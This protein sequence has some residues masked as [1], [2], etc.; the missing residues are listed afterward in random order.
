MKEIK[1]LDVAKIKRKDKASKIV[2]AILRT[3][4]IVGLSFIIILP[5]I[6]SAIPALTDFNY[7]GEP[8]SIWLPKKSSGLSFKIASDLMDYKSSLPKTIFFAISIS[9]IQVIVSA[10]VGYGFTTLGK[11]SGKALFALVILTIILPPQA[12]MLPQ[13]MYFTKMGLI[14]NIG[15][16]Y[17]LS[18]F[19]MGLKSGLFIY[20]FK[21]F[22]QGLPKELE[23]AA[24]IDGCGYVGTFFRVMLP[25][26]TS[27]MLTVFVFAFVW[28]FGD[29]HYTM[30]F[31]KDANLMPSLVL[32]KV[33]NTGY[34]KGSFANATFLNPDDMPLLFEGSVRGAGLILY[35]APLA[36]FYFLIQRSFVQGFER[37][38]ITGQ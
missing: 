29:L 11:G 13:F 31:A 30:W 16:I 20:L 38:G 37:S 24:A 17:L 7:L 21:Q 18:T 5:I 14:G 10:F 27:V 3:F 28:N 35:I 23:E 36:L 26:A 4:I 19:A 12:I 2:I 34:V 22:F 8:T 25:N 32:E 15:A 1:K 6:I 9:I 33:L